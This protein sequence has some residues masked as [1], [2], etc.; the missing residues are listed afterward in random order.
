MGKLSTSSHSR[1][2][3]TN[4]MQNKWWNSNS[5]WSTRHFLS[6]CQ[7]STCPFPWAR[8]N[9]RTTTWPSCPKWCCQSIHKKSTFVHRVDQRNPNYFH[10]TSPISSNSFQLW[11]FCQ[12]HSIAIFQSKCLFQTRM[13]SIQESMVNFCRACVYTQIYILL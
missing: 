4:V 9:L 7:A 1:H 11:L 2:W 12:M 6:V 8:A 5:L 13:F 3:S 10:L